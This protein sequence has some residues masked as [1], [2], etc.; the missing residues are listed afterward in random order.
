MVPWDSVEGLPQR[1][2]EGHLYCEPIFVCLSPLIPQP[3]TGDNVATDGH[4][5]LSRLEV[6]LT[7]TNKFEGLETDADHNSTQSLLLRW[8]WWFSQATLL[9]IQWSH[10]ERAIILPCRHPSPA[11]RSSKSSPQP[12]SHSPCPE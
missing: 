6:S 2:T 3:I 9:P 8:V 5:D 12:S 1:Y 7:L 4:E 11:P 10:S